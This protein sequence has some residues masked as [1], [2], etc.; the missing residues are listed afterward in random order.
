MKS[1]VLT[2]K[3]RAALKVVDL[4]KAV[5]LADNHFLSAAIGRLKVETGAFA[6]PFATDGASLGVN[7]DLLCT[8]F[9]TEREAPKHDLMHS[10]L[11][12]VFLH[13]YI[14]PSIDA[15]L[16]S[17]AC[18]IAVERNVAKICGSRSGERRKREADAISLIEEDLGGIVTAEKVYHA[19]GTG[20]WPGSAEE[21]EALFLADDHALWYMWGSPEGI[22]AEGGPGRA[23]SGAGSVGAPA[24]SRRG[25]SE[26][27]SDEVRGSI[28]LCSTT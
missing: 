7:A 10:V 9:M 13:P 6:Q 23:P 27:Q 24:S 8:Q 17:L 15:R 14:A 22:A 1:S 21:W 20:K 3:E 11:H 28:P 18:D 4:A 2:D 5:A 19:L 16:W 26:V 25:G 12:C